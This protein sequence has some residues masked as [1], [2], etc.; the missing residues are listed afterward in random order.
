M[1]CQLTVN[2]LNCIYLKLK[3]S[4]M[5]G[6]SDRAEEWDAIVIGSGIGGL[7][8]AGLLAGV[9]GKKVLV[10]EKHSEPGGLTHMFRRDG[11]SWDVGVHYV[12]EVDKGSLAR[13]FLDF[14]SEGRLK[15]N[16]MPENFE[17]FVY[18]GLSFEVP[19]DPLEYQK[20]LVDRFPEEAPAIRRYFRDIH[21]V[22]RWNVKGFLSIFMPPFLGS[23]IKLGMRRGMSAATTT[24]G[25]YLQDRFASPALRALM[26]SQWGDYGLPPS[27]SAFAIHATIVGHYLHGAWF[28]HGGAG[29]IARTFERGIESRGGSVRV[30][31][32]VTSIIVEKGRA[33]G[34]RAID[35]RGE[36][37]QEVVHTAPVI[38]SDAGARM[39]YGRLLPADG[40][41]GE[42]T[43]RVRSF[44]AGLE[45]GGSAVTLYLRLKAP[46]STIG[47]TGANVWINTDIDHD[48]TPAQ[49]QE[50][51]EGRP[52]HIYVSFPS[53]KS[54]E[55]RFH[56]AE[57]ITFLDAAAFASWKEKPHGNRGSDYS[58][59]KEKISDGLVDL[60]ETAIPGLKALISYRELS[61]PLTVEHF[62]SHLLGRFYGLPA[63]PRRYAENVLGPGTPI[64]GLYLAGSDAGSLGIVGSLMGGV[65]AAAR[66][67]GSFGFFRI[68]ASIRRAEGSPTVTPGSPE[69]KKAVLAAKRRLTPSIWEMRWRLDEP[70]HF[71]PGQFARLRVAD[72]EWRDYSLAAVEGAEIMLLVSTRTGGT[73][74]RFAE[75]AS[76][77]TESAIELPLGSYRLLRSTRR[78][79]FVATGTGIAPFLPMLNELHGR[80]EDGN[81]ELLF[82]CGTRA[83]NLLSC[84]PAILPSATLLC[85]SREA[86]QAGGFSGRV[87]A[88]LRR[89]A[90][91]PQGTDFYVC[92]SAA[93]VADCRGIL[94]TAGALHIHTEAY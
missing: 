61:T 39:T 34:V 27:Q 59:L 64:P 42:K 66:T 26:A 28:P 43:A 78:K 18:P 52:R 55:D 68:M 92:G 32:E 63:V 8:A 85:M 15:W 38:I 20:R 76:V 3:E 53:A 73:G 82:G 16:R 81:V 54:G 10:L 71:A 4:G 70:V 46:V 2:I 17:R 44:I 91:D 93:M 35:R 31:N 90:F 75:Q 45:G 6:M 23:L 62:T 80:G 79:V 41:I 56:T 11:A 40:E 33:V 65:A 87:T 74:S 24:T 21:R 84:F 50:I 14:L 69:K 37:P 36:E 9:A 19:S 67:L 47:I 1:S 60:A 94:E 58:A 83:D 51:L 5:V 77:G 72:D 88:A 57:I 49:A 22:Q 48:S 13:S 29:R 12:G 30:C 25:S 7:T 86:P 89:R